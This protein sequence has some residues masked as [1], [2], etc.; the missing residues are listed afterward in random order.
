MFAT[1]TKDDPDPVVGLPGLAAVCAAVSIPVVA[2]GG[3][4]LPRAAEVRAA[5]PALAAVISAVCGASDPERTAAE[6]HAALRA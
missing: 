3:I 5:G 4:T 1:Q 6:L 2:I